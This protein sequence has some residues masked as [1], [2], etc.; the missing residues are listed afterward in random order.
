MIGR[1]IGNPYLVA[2]LAW[3]VLAWLACRFIQG[4]SR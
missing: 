1:F 2:F 4:T 3:V